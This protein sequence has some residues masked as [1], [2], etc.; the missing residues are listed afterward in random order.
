MKKRILYVVIALILAL[1]ALLI[2]IARHYTLSCEAFAETGI[3]GDIT[4]D[5]NKILSE[6]LNYNTK[7]YKNI[8]YKQDGSVAQIE[9]NTETINVVCNEI[10]EDIYNLI[11]E[12]SRFYGIPMGNTLGSSFLSGK[13]PK[14]RVN[15]VP[16]GYVNYSIS[17]ELL[18]GGINQTLHRI[19]AVFSIEIRC[20]APFHENK[21]EIK[22]P[23]VLSEVLI[24]GPVPEVLFPS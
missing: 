6:G 8:I 20:L 1:C 22:I 3:K 24:A 7:E 4:K 21:T 2:R 17:S 12:R 16:I 11:C 9:I 13:G 5:I 23:L 19:T 15:I 18:S 14:L 10:S